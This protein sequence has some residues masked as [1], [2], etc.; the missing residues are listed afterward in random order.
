MEAVESRCAV[1]APEMPVAHLAE[2]TVRSRPSHER[3]FR[4]LVVDDNRDAADSLAVIVRLWGHD[5]QVAYDGLVAFDAVASYQPDVILL[6]IGLPGMDGFALASAITHQPAWSDILIVSVSAYNDPAFV[7]KLVESGVSEHF[8]KP[9]NLMALKATLER[10][11]R[12]QRAA[13]E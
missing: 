4:V 13:A 11:K 7:S 10:H 12:A 3:E 6:D 8:P 1:C 2:D 5:V 9:V